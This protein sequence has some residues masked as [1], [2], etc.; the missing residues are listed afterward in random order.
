MTA[1]LYRNPRYV[2]LTRERV[3]INARRIDG[4]ITEADHARFAEIGAELVAM[5][6]GRR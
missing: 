4:T 5:M 3:A 2:A 6:A 1:S